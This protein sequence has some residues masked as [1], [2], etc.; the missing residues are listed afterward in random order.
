[1]TKAMRTNDEQL[2]E[3]SFVLDNTTKDDYVYDGN[4]RLNLF[5]KDVDYFWYSLGFGAVIHHE[6]TGESVDMEASILAHNPKFITGHRLDKSSALFLRYEQTPYEGLYV[7][8]EA[9]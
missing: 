2:A 6:L 7:I 8:K 4:N 1:M 5:R 3:I 9:P